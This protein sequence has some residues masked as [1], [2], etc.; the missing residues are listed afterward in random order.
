MQTS[1]GD[2]RIALLN[3]T[4]QGH[5][6]PNVLSILEF[7][8]YE[9]PCKPLTGTP[10]HA[11]VGSALLYSL[12]ILRHGF[13]FLRMIDKSPQA[14]WLRTSSPSMPRF[15]L[16]PLIEPSPPGHSLHST[17]FWLSDKVTHSLWSVTHPA[18]RPAL[19][20]PD[21]QVGGGVLCLLPDRCPFG[22]EAY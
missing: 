10:A 22:L 17:A 1:G 16:A 12:G 8:H 15:I 21:H 7:L 5:Q 4:P 13:C 11:T 3:N 20:P 19:F 9:K 2:P 6:T 18:G 14:P